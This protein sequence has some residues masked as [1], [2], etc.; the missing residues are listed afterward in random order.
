MK[1]RLFI[2]LARPVH[3]GLQV[4]SLRLAQHLKKLGHDVRIVA[5]F[6]EARPVDYVR[7][8]TPRVFSVEGVDVEIISVQ[9][10]RC[11]LLPLVSLLL[12]RWK[13]FPL[14]LALYQAAFRPAVDR[15][16]KG[17]DLAHYF[18]T[19]AELLGFAVWAS[20][21]RKNIPFVVEPAIHVGQWGEGPADLPLYKGADMVVAHTEFE[22]EALRRHGVKA[23]HVHALRVGFDEFE[24][25]DGAKFRSAHGIEGPMVL[26]VGRRC[27]VK[28]YFLLLVAFA[29]LRNHLPNVTLVI[30]GPGEAAPS[31]AEGVLELGRVTDEIK[32]DAFDACT[33][34]CLP[35]MGESFGMAYFE[36]WN[37][38][39]PVVALD[40]PVL[41]E[42]IGASGGGL[43][44]APDRPGDLV[45]K[46]RLLLEQPELAVAMGA[47]GRE[48]SRGY[49]WNGA[50]QS[51]LEAYSQAQQNQRQQPRS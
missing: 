34:F 14:A 49:S 33:V 44:A 51:C 9:G 3:G 30:A 32:Q 20:A 31:T 12:R 28:G 24:P 45:E 38:G 36:A 35:S 16:L 15:A 17:A 2:S 23:S 29:T 4:L 50:T 40:L 21:R 41:H 8:E 43:L 22:A 47:R 37:R 10:W 39:K 6:T 7:M 46:L 25:G 42:T 11:W 26:F 18:G 19:G 5:R 1:I 27:E 48:F 13:T